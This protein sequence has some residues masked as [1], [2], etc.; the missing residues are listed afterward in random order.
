MGGRDNVLNWTAPQA[1]HWF[2]IFR[3][4]CNNSW[5]RY[6]EDTS[7]RQIQFSC[8]RN[9]Y[10]S[11]WTLLLA[12]R[13]LLKSSQWCQTQVSNWQSK[14]SL[15]QW[16]NSYYSGENSSGWKRGRNAGDTGLQYNRRKIH[17][18]SQLEQRQVG[19]ILGGELRINVG[20]WSKIQI[21]Q[22]TA[23]WLVGS[24]PKVQGTRSP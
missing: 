2:Q 1:R 12:A 16:S 22:N 18:S 24:Q 23:R 17:H 4:R 6:V 10:R 20:I 11:A 7:F 15:N 19:G 21:S 8:T 3:E 14:S 9:S 5:A 13:L